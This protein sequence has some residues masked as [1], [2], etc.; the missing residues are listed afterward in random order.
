MDKANKVIV[1]TGAT[2]RQGGAAAAHLLADGWRVRAVVRDTSTSSASA[3]V[4]AGAEAAA[5]APD[6]RVSLDAALRGAYGVYS[7]QPSSDRELSQGRNVADAAQA[8]GVEHLVYLSVGGQPANRAIAGSPSG[9]SRTTSAPSTFRRPSCGLP[10]SWRTL[11]RPV[12]RPDT[13][14]RPSGR[15]SN[16]Q[17]GDAKGRSPPV[18]TCHT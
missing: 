15:C 8:A 17:S 14:D 1:V 9:T 18:V 6:D 12:H 3:L 13:G 7:V 10:A 4:R 11:P 5:A 16:P 2:G